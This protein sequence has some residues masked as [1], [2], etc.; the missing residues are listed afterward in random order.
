MRTW[1]FKALCLT[2]I[3][4]VNSCKVTETESELKILTTSIEADAAGGTYEIRYEATGAA[5]MLS[6]AAPGAEDWISNFDASA[7]GVLTFEVRPNESNQAR[8]ATV[9]IEC[10]GNSG[11]CIVFQSG[12]RPPEYDYDVEFEATV[13]CR[14]I[15]YGDKYS[16]GAGNYFITFGDRGTSGN[17]SNYVEPDGTYYTFDFYGE[18]WDGDMSA[19]GIPEGTYVLDPEN[20]GA[21]GTFSQKYGEYAKADEFGYVSLSMAYTSGTCTIV[22]SNDEYKVDITVGLEDGTLHHV[23]YRGPIVCEESNSGPGYEYIEDDIDFGMNIA[24]AI[25]DAASETILLQFTNMQ[26]DAGGTVVPPGT[27]LNITANM[28]VSEDGFLMEAT[29]TPD[30]DLGVNTFLP[31]E[32][33]SVNGVYLP[34]G[35]YA[36][37]YYTN[38]HVA[39]GIIV[40][41]TVSFKGSD[42]IYDIDIDLVTSEGVH[43]RAK[44]SSVS[45]PLYGWNPENDPNTTLPGDYE[46]NLTDAKA[47]ASYYGDYYGC[48]LDNWILKLTPTSGTD[49]F[50][51]EYF[52]DGTGLFDEGLP[53]GTFTAG[54]DPGQGKF[55]IG[56]LEG[57]NMY[58]TWFIGGYDNYGSATQYA[59]AMDGTVTVTR[60]QDNTYTLSVD[61]Y[62]DA[63]DPNN[64]TGTWTGEVSIID[65]SSLPVSKQS[66]EHPGQVLHGPQPQTCK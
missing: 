63:F 24:Q 16:P 12:V 58:G 54:T 57:Y 65:Q 60:N 62:D 30:Q 36:E 18:L 2:M 27:L 55:V 47:V 13:Q 35:T 37:Q 14:G 3:V 23:T 41:G 52:G 46:L 7:S 17:N 15:Y 28:N 26:T 56:Y 11:E 38:M 66:T 25:Y 42:G 4:A 53:T 6:A 34:S 5:V 40:D 9:R 33:L 10:N 29:L 48:G 22:K 51:L 39:Y 61:L 1:L 49:G 44:E 21:K 19:I 32:M 50:Q 64:F 20:T 8:Q 31:G 43:I 59:P 45:F